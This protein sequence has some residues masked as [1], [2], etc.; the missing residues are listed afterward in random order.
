MATQALIVQ[1]TP[2]AITVFPC[3]SLPSLPCA[4]LFP[5][6]PPQQTSKMAAKI[7][8]QD[9]QIRCVTSTKKGSR[10]AEGKHKGGAEGRGW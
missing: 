5:P 2:K 4:F 8:L 7:E 6:S 1:S 9:D 10:D 3:M